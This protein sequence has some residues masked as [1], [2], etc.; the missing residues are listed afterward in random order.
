MPTSFEDFE[1]ISISDVAPRLPDCITRP[2]PKWEMG[3][4]LEADTLIDYATGSRSGDLGLVQGLCAK[5]TNS[6]PDFGKIRKWLDEAKRPATATE[7]ATCIESSALIQARMKT[8]VLGLEPGLERE[9]TN[10]TRWA[11]PRSFRCR[12]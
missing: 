12:S 10:W 2:V 6:K 4:L 1:P 9:A 7:V 5:L 11:P 3:L 8:A